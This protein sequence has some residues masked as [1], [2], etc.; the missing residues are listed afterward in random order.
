[1]LYPAFP[2]CFRL[3]KSIHPIASGRLCFSQIQIWL[4]HWELRIFHQLPLTAVRSALL[5][6]TL[7]VFR[8][9][10]AL[11]LDILAPRPDRN[12][13]R[14]SR[15]R[16]CH[17]IHT[18]REWPIGAM[19]RHEKPV[20]VRQWLSLGDCYR[21]ATASRRRRARTSS[22]R[23]PLIST[24]TLTCRTSTSPEIICSVLS[25]GS[26]TPIPGQGHA[27]ESFGAD[28]GSWAGGCTA[29]SR[30]TASSVRTSGS[31]ITGCAGSCSVRLQWNRRIKLRLSSSA[32][33]IG[34][35][36]AF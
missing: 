5:A 30:R 20:A 7:S 13:E 27:S 32:K 2:S 33:V 11:Q 35:Q 3:P 21:S 24:G 18:L 26:D 6:S 34:C 14:R 4:I 36:T 10:A 28:A 19:Y 22:S 17:D 8:T 25:R 23:W 15:L 12:C 1:M 31:L 9:R 16:R 29:A